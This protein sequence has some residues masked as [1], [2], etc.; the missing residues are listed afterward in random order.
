MRL[1]GD[2][3]FGDCISDLEIFFALDR[4]MASCCFHF[5]ESLD[6]GAEFCRFAMVTGQIVGIKEN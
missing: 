5:I 6:L 4:A 3:D 1:D 2:K